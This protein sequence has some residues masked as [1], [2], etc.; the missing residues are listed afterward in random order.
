MVIKSSEFKASYVEVDKCPQVKMPEFAFIG[1]SNVGKSSLINYL[2]GRKALS[3]VSNTPGKTQT[4]NYFQINANFHLVDLPGYSFARVSKE[5]RAKWDAMIRNYLKKREQ[6][7]YVFLLVD[8]RIPP[9]Q[10][11]LNFIRWLAE[12]RVPFAIVFTKAD[13]PGS[14]EVSKTVQVFKDLLL[15]DWEELPPVFVT[16]AERNAGRNEIWEFV[17]KAVNEYYLANT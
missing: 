17:D 2:C 15:K 8:S 6:L 5:Q 4:I 9:Q 16:S 14:K 12:N 10:V 3:K 1:R 7:Q 11:D 13:K